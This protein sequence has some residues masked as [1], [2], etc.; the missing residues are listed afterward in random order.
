MHLLTSFF[1]KNK[2]ALSNN[3]NDGQETKKQR[4]ASSLELSF[5]KALD[6]DVFKD[7]LKCKDCILILKRCMENI[8]KKMEELCLATKNTKESQIKSELQLVSTNEKINFIS[9]KFD[10]WIDVKKTKLLKI[11][12]KNPSEMAQRID[13]L[14]NLVDQQE[15]YSRRN[16]LLVHGI[17]E[18]NDKNTDDLAVKT[19]N[20]R[21]AVN[22]TESKI[23]RSHRIGRKKDGQRPRSIIVKLTRYNT[24]KF[25]LQVRES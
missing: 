21:L 20:E 3:S 13:K 18:T 15:Q 23:D 5:E 4:E 9:E 11:C 16:C 12:Q 19:I 22:I 8:E 17:A 7:S 14:E 6:G 10:K 25:F 2:R 1:D 24:R